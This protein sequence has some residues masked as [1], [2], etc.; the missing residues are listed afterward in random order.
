MQAC[1][2]PG[3]AVGGEELGQLVDAARYEEYRVALHLR[4]ELREQGLDRVERR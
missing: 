3:E 1:A 4:L 2:H